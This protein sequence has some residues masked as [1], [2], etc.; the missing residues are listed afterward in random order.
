MVYN[1]MVCIHVRA[2]TSRNF[3]HV[4]FFQ[5]F[6]INRAAEFHLSYPSARIILSKIYETPKVQLFRRIET[7]APLLM[8]FLLRQFF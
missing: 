7:V 4:Y 6:I 2:N 1:A 8:F 5:F 3:V